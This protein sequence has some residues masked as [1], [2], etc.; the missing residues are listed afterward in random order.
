MKALRSLC[1]FCGSNVGARPE[2]ADAARSLG[3]L[4][5]AESITLVYGGGSV[6]LMGV[7]ADAALDAGGKVVGVIPHSL[8]L[9]E[10]G[11]S[12]LTQMYVVD[13]M[14]ERKALMADLADA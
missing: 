2:Y 3:K 11:H 1:V 12:R 10:V 8:K 9:K 5:A 4:F 13:T 6:G 7:L 14:H